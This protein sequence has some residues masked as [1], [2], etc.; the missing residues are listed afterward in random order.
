[1]ERLRGLFVEVRRRRVLEVVAIY[2]GLGF[3]M[4]QGADIVIPALNLSPTL[5]TALTVLVLLGLPVAAVVGWI[6][7]LDA[8]GRLSRTPPAAD[9][10]VDDSPAGE[11]DLPFRWN[12]LLAAIGAGV[13]VLAASW[14]I[15][16]RLSTVG[17][18][19]AIEDPRGSYLVAPLGL[20]GPSADDAELAG[21]VA[22]RLTR[23]LRGWE[24]LRTVSTAAYDGMASRLGLAHD[25]PPSL[26]QALEM[27]MSQR[28]GSLIGLELEVD[29]D[30]VYLE[31]LLYDVTD[32]NE[33]GS[34]ILTAGSTDDLD[35]LVAPIAQR[36]LQIRDQDTS[37]DELRRESP[38]PDAHQDFDAGLDALRDWRL[39]EAERQFRATIERDSMFAN[40]LH[41]LALTLFWQTARESRLVLE[42]GPEMARLTQAAVRAVETRGVRPV[43]RDHIE[44]FRAFWEGDYETARE[45]YGRILA[46]DSSDVEAWLLLG[47]VELHDSA[48][49]STPRGP[50]PRRNLNLARRAFETAANLA[51]DWQLSYGLLFDI[52]RDLVDA[53]RNERCPG[54]N[55]PGAPQRAPFVTTKAAAQVGFCPVVGDSIEWIPYADLAGT[56]RADAIANAA[57]LAQRSRE[58]LE[59]WV[60]IHSDQ[61]RPHE[62][63]ANWLTWRRSSFGC[64][65]D[66][67]SLRQVTSE[68]LRERERSLELRGD[69]M[70]ADLLRLAMLRMATD[71]VD[72]ARRL[73]SEGMSRIGNETV[74]SEAANI[75]VALGE[76]DTAI[77]LMRPVWS[78][79][80]WGTRDPDGGPPVLAADVAEPIVQIRLRGAAGEVG[81]SL[82]TPFERLFDTWSEPEYSASQS[83]HLRSLGLRLGLGPGLAVSPDVRRRWFSGWEEAGL[84]VPVLWRGFLAADSEAGTEG[85]LPEVERALEAEL[86]RLRDAE[87]TS[88]EDHFLA[89]LLAQVTGRHEVAVDQLTQVESCPLS[90]HAL[91][92]GW[93]LRT[94]ARWYRARSSDALG[95]RASASEAMAAYSA[96]RRTG[97]TEVP[98]QPGGF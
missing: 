40:A 20:R 63:L 89:G 71:D 14:L 16:V 92:E 21:R 29:G 44:A 64:Q 81:E 97:S 3:A 26:S 48:L 37:I 24:T 13:L 78:T 41:Y 33:F 60:Q 35:G 18:A 85:H 88:A 7:D 10:E 84:Q 43:F 76:A 59:A 9:L 79:W 94:M 73:M 19:Y 82:S 75:H 77:A 6:Y 74:P 68:I 4:L 72:A 30:S 98:N 28:A 67:D 23:Q 22:R 83:A 5:L 50:T 86:A 80:S 58:L 90:L 61:A 57:N 32:A 69:T 11:H 25:D 42:N 17:T 56:R 70:P 62:E 47:A 46:A 34:P 8:R 31:A 93:G 87:T 53:A 66:S 51:P 96:Y 65:Q 2:G 49:E 54:F 39:A 45:V 55:P 38:N 1:M 12:R 36:I 27:A 15:A 52:D 91:S 95:D